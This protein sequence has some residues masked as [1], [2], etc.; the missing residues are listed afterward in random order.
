MSENARRPRPIASFALIFFAFL[1]PT[2]TQTNSTEPV[3][4]TMNAKAD[5]FAKTQ[6]AM[7]N[8]AEY[9]TMIAKDP[10]DLISANNLGALYFYAG[11]YDE[12]LDL[13]RRA[14]DGRPSDWH[15]QVNASILLRRH[16]SMEDALK[17]A[18]AA[19][20]IAPKDVRVRQELCDLYLSVQNG[21]DALACYGSLTADDSGDA[22]DMLG[23]GEALLLTGD[24][25]KAEG[26]I[27][28]AIAASPRL[29][30]AYNALGMSLFQQKQYSDAIDPFR[31]AISL[32][33]DEPRFRFNMGIA[34]M[35]A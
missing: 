12:A 28:K 17:Y 33:P 19:Y 31:T 26:M 24:P 35:A 14:A 13:I 27:R 22:E 10:T 6:P 25:E 18:Q 32:N 23:Y 8:I 16:G 21:S 34:Q 29:A 1:T 11:R 20:K 2:L 3:A 15:I 5:Q 7:P 9:E 4:L 30:P